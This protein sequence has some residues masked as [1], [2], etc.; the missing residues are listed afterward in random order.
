MA[1]GVPGQPFS[2]AGS[3]K[4]RSLVDEDVRGEQDPRARLWEG[5]VEIVRG[6]SQPR[7]SSR[8]FPTSPRWDE[9]AVLSAF[10]DSLS[11]LGYAVDARVLDGFRRGVPQHRQRLFLIALAGGRRVSWPEGSGEL[12]TLREAIGER[13]RPA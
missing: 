8:T 3:S 6:S 10:Y 2:R 5:F 12:V 13:E 4:L 7:S 11:D 9:G 1:G